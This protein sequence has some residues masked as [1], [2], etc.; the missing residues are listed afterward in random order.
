VR[1]ILDEEQLKKLDKL[2]KTRRSN[3]HRFLPQ[4]ERELI[5]DDYYRGQ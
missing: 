2:R 4:I 1:S 5:F 3:A